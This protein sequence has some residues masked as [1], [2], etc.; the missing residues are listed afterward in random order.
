[1]MPFSLSLLSPSFAHGR[2]LKT[3]IGRW[4]L[5]EGSSGH[6]SSVNF[7]YKHPLR[8][9]YRFGVPTPWLEPTTSYEVRQRAKLG[10]CC[11]NRS[12]QLFWD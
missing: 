8:P 11:Q 6:A 12:F 10:S 5:R 9:P 2:P 3:G 4:W 7:L 1:M